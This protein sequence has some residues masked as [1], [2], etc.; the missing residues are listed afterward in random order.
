[1]ISCSQCRS[2]TKHDQCQN[3]AKLDQSENGTD[4]QVVECSDCKFETKNLRYL[5]GHIKLMHGPNADVSNV[6]TCTTCEFETE[7]KQYLQHHTNAQH[8]NQK[9][10]SCNSCDFKSYYKLC[11][12]THISSKHEGFSSAKLKKIDCSD[13]KLNINHNTCIRAQ[14]RPFQQRPNQSKNAAFTG[15][16]DKICPDCSYVTQKKQLSEKTYAI[17]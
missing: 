14:I 1:M 10:F 4:P 16:K 8:L 6:L 13:C 2:G 12:K 9:R 3:T 17:V 7:N 11:V 5:S 15:R